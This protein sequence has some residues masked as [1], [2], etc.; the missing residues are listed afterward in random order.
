MKKLIPILAVIL[1]FGCEVY[2]VEEPIR[3]D[4]RD[5]F[6]GAYS[7][8]DYSQTTEQLYTYEIYITKSCCSSQ[9]IYIDNFYGVDIEVVGE[10]YG[11]KVTIP[12]QLIND[13][14]IEGTGKIVNSTLHLSYI[15]R[16]YYEMPVFTDF[17]SS[18]GWKM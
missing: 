16:D 12:R 1:F 9:E 3:W 2:I 5:E 10:V 13:Y 17:V 4:D 11:N 8:E 15:V 18:T 7:V 14:E 6:V